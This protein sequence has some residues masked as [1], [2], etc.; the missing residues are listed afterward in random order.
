MDAGDSL[1][2]HPRNKRL[3]GERFALMALAKTY[4]MK[5]IGYQ[6]P[7]YRKMEIK[8]A[9]V[10]LIFDDAPVGLTSWGRELKAFEVAGSDRVFYPAKAK[11]W[12]G[13]VL[14]SCVDVPHPIAVRYAFH[15]Y[16]NGDLFGNNGLPVSSF[17]T[18]NW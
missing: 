16:A 11:I 6:S 7:R 15:D 8:D 9:E 18:D 14:V 17:R 3:P 13:K 2:I 5:G 10:T 1:T 12:G 4:G